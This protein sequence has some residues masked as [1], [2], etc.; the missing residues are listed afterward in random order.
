MY[1]EPSHHVEQPFSGRVF[2]VEVHAVTLPDGAS[3]RREIVRHNGGACVLAL[4]SR[5]CVTMVRQYRKAFDC[6]LL[7]IPA[8]KLEKGEDPL[9]CARRELSEETGLSADRFQWLTTFYPSPGYTSEILHIYLA[10]GLTP[11]QAHLDKGEF[12]SCQ[13]LPL[14]TLLEMVDRGEIRDAKTV[15]ALLLTARLLAGD[16]GLICGTEE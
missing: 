6:E 9:D 16:P 10:T 7:E 15:I 14:D 3:S 13:T 1:H 11:G 12:L 8:G 4:D 5:R 2:N